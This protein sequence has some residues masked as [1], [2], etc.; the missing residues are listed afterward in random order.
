MSKYPL[1]D[2]VCSICGRSFETRSARGIYCSN[3]C[4]ERGLARAIDRQTLRRKFKQKVGIPRDKKF[5]LSDE[6]WDIVYDPKMTPKEKWYAL[7]EQDRQRVMI[8]LRRIQKET[9]ETIRSMRGSP[10]SA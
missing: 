1:R 8:V 3:D 5:N 4:R 9:E 2:V 6:G 7:P 10:A